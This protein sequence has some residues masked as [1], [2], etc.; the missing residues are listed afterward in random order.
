MVFKKKVFFSFLSAFLLYNSVSAYAADDSLKIYNLSGEIVSAPGKSTVFFVGIDI[1]E[2][3]YIYANPKGPGTGMATEI[4][5][6]FTF[7]SDFREVRYIKGT[8]YRSEGDTADVFIY[9]EKTKAGISF[10]PSDKVKPGTYSLKLKVKALLCGYGACIPFETA[11]SFP[12]KIIPAKTFQEASN[13][14]A[15]KEFLSMPEGTA[16]FETTDA[17]K[18]VESGRMVSLIKSLKFSPVCPERGIS[19]LIEAILLGILAGFILNFMPCVLPVVSLKILSFMENAHRSRKIIFFQG[20]LFSSGIITS[21]LV[22]ATLAAFWGY[23]WGELFQNRVFIVFMAAFVFAMALSMFNVYIINTPAFTGKLVSKRR[24]IYPDAFV[25]GVVATLLATPCSGPL[26]GG[27][28]AWVLRRPPVEI[29]AVFLSIGVGMALPYVILTARP[30]LIRYIPKP[31][32][33]TEVFEE[34]MGFLLMLTALYLVWISDLSFRMNL[35]LYLFF[36]AMAFWQYGRFGSLD[37]S[38]I[39]RIISEVM[40][41]AILAGGYFISFY[42]IEK[43]ADAEEKI[44]FSMERVLANRDNGVISVID[45]TADWCPNCKLVEKTVLEDERILRLFAREDVD[46]MI[47]DITVTHPEAEALMHNMG[48]SS[49]PFLAIIPPGEGFKTPACVRD[50]YSVSNVIE[51]IA[52]AEKFIKKK[53]GK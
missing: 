13:E 51:G 11:V 47:A 19:G 32:E 12:V 4:T 34:V 38:R 22:L 41:V 50:I 15:M 21:F 27:V 36:V 26:L 46:F 5:P 39:S 1:P 25:K 18:I 42:Y 52:Y 20:L 31:G 44:A 23:K 3:Y 43:K 35:V 14:A 45:F 10:L 30:A 28:L 8:V 48:S 29:F 37:R 7:N 40:L 17:K 9:K 2:G 16:V 53:K 6:S 24:N 49:I 33:W